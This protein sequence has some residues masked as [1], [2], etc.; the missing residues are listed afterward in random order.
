MD[1]GGNW[2]TTYSD[3]VTNLLCFFVML[4]SMSVIDAQKFETFSRSIRNTFIKS[5]SAG[6][7]LYHNMG[8]KILTVNFINPD[9]TGK[10]IV[11]NERYIQTAE[12]IILDDRERIREEKFE[13]AKEQLKQDISELGISNQVD[14]IEEKEYILIRLNEK[15]LFKPGSAEILED[16]KN[17]LKT[18][19]ESLKALDGEIIVEGHTDTVPINTPLFPTNWELSTR[20]ATNVVIYLVNE[21]GIAPSRLTAAGCG[22]YRPIADN[23]TAEGRSKNRRIE[24]KVMK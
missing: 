17:T 13:K 9:D 1:F 16:G 19:G 3:L 2:L 7:I 4:F 10:K 20:R 14:L 15:V 6:T 24:I 21:I 12:G 8:K 22:E 18:L 11:D 5:G 23:N